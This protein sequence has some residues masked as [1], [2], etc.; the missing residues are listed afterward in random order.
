MRATV[1]AS[2]HA[3]LDPP[4]DGLQQLVPDRVPKLS[5][6]ALNRSRSR[7]STATRLPAPPC[8]RERDLEAIEEQDPVRQSGERIVLRLVLGARTFVHLEH[9]VHGDEE[10]QDARSG[11]HCRQLRRLARCTLHREQRRREQRQPQ[12]CREPSGTQSGRTHHRVVDPPAKRR[13]ERSRGPEAHTGEPQN[14][15]PPDWD[16]ENVERPEREHRIDDEQACERA[17]DVQETVGLG[18]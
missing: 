9:E 3:A 11:Q 17:G 10:W 2:R 18:T 12:R 1:S 13:H 7:N 14:L 16:L 15:D 4:R 8:C 5:L 6:I